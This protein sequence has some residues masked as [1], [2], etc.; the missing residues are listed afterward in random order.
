MSHGYEIDTL[1]HPVN[2][3]LGMKTDELRLCIEEGMVV[4]QEEGNQLFTW[5]YIASIG[6]TYARAS[7]EFVIGND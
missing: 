5:D 7:G 2:P 1:Y 3:T 4:L 6:C